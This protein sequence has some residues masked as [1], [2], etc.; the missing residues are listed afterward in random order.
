MR[1]IKTIKNFLLIF[2]IFI[3]GT[4]ATESEKVNGESEFKTSN[5]TSRIPQND[6]K[7]CWGFMN[8]LSKLGRYFPSISA[9]FSIPGFSSPAL[10]T[11]S[12]EV[13]KEKKEVFENS[14]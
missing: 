3:K 8:E 14:S 10:S 6:Q 4:V 12:L 5:I 11:P 1:R 9:G 2:S 7:K 13:Q